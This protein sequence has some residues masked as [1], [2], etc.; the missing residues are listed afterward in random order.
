MLDMQPLVRRKQPQR[1]KQVQQGSPMQPFART[2]HSRPL[3][4]LP[5][6]LVEAW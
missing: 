2:A 5:L 6:V 4:R 3:P 1:V